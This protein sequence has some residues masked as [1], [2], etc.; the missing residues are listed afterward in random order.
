MLPQAE[1][2]RRLV[3]EELRTVVYNFRNAHRY[4]VAPSRAD[5][6]A[7]PDDDERKALLGFDEFN[8]V[9]P[10]NGETDADVQHSTWWGEIDM[11]TSTGTHLYEKLKDVKSVWLIVDLH[12]EQ[13]MDERPWCKVVLFSSMREDKFKG[14][15]GGG[16]GD[17]PTLYMPPWEQ[18]EAVRCVDNLVDDL[19][20]TRSAVEHRFAMFGGSARFLFRP[21]DVSANAV[22]VALREV[23]V[24]TLAD[25][26]NP[27]GT[28]PTLSS[29]L[30]HAVVSAD[31]KR[32]VGKRF[33]SEAIRDQ[34][35]KKLASSTAFTEGVW[36]A[37]TSG[38]DIVGSR[39]FYFEQ[40]WHYWA[41]N[42]SGKRVR[43][44]LLGQGCTKTGGPR[45]KASAGTVTDCTLCFTQVHPTARIPAKNVDSLTSLAVNQYA[46]PT[47]PNFP[48]VDGF[49]VYSG[50]LWKT[51]SASASL[52]SSSS[53]V[54]LVLWQ[55]TIASDNK[56]SAKGAQLDTII[57]KCLELCG[58][59]TF[60]RVVLLYAVE[61]IEGFLFQPYRNAEKKEYKDVPEKTRMTLDHIEQYAVAFGLP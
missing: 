42:P 56:H 57:T 50:N 7:L 34:L 59:K 61:D 52:S 39:A 5:L 13:W 35:F 49:G 11:G 21:E 10:M 16:G 60:D 32:I 23:N 45:K 58:R 2:V 53:A 8:D 55:M 14:L 36:L 17:V 18:D 4:I 51:T 41:Q 22:E 28:N 6:E 38:M 19:H 54:S 24:R 31:Y 46:K 33:A 1:V 47:V 26:L 12:K 29:V 30:V 3:G 27:Q 25:A 15:V 40:L 43:L 37:A 20:L 9:E 44:K 48:A